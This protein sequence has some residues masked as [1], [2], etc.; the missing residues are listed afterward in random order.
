MTRLKPAYSTLLVAIAAGIATYAYQHQSPD[1][2][3]IDGY[4]HL[5]LSALIAENGLVHSLTW[6]PYT[7]YAE[8]FVDDRLGF[9]LLLIPFIGDDPI[10][11]GH[12]Y[13]SVLSA[14]VFAAFHWIL[15]SHDIRWPAAW[16]LGLA[17]SSM[18]FVFRLNLVRAPSLSLL[19][20]LLGCWIIL[21]GRDRWLLP[22]GFV[23]AWSYGGFPVLIAQAGIAAGVMWVEGEARWK[24]LGWTTL[25]CA[26][27]VILNPYF[28]ANVEFLWQSFTEIE[29]GRFPAAVI[30]GNEDYPYAT[31]TAVRKTLLVCVI[32]FAAILAYLI[33]PI[34]LPQPA[35]FLFLFSAAL[36]CL[37]L[38]ARRFV[39][40]WPPFAF[41]FAAFA[42]QHWWTAAPSRWRSR[43]RP[44]L[45]VVVPIVCVFAGYHTV[46]GLQ[47]ARQPE[48][49]PAAYAGASD[50]LR[51]TVARDTVI[52]HASW[53]DFPLLFFQNTNNRY[54]AGLGLHYLYL[55]SPDLHATYTRLCAGDD[56]T[57]SATIVSAFGARYA[58]S[59]KTNPRLLASLDADTGTERVYEDQHAVVFR[60]AAR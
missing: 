46:T 13:A 57:P 17:V 28:P 43:L 2:L 36:L 7:I 1:L 49:S 56:P 32:T 34:R 22:L 3:G 31:S 5:K 37:Y 42:L 44:I 39:E 20:L 11:G 23:F 55:A 33:R 10:A 8:T 60:L 18:S 12:L 53:G 48:R 27:G 45:L 47:D 15:A 4:F 58:F 29:L 24:V 41:L 59:R 9:H 40:Y 30:A 51:A 14:A 50:F 26:A 16:T 25:G 52:F 6:L 35:L 54:I 21:A 38:V 19:L